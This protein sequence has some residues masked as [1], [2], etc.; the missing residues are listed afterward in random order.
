MIQQPA[1]IPRHRL[2]GHWSPFFRAASSV[3]RPVFAH[4]KALGLITGLIVAVGVTLPIVASMHPLGWATSPATNARSGEAYVPGA[5]AGY[6]GPEDWA[7]AEGG[8]IGGYAYRPGPLAGYDGPEVW[9]LAEGGPFGSVILP[10]PEVVQDWARAEGG[11]F[12]L[13]AY[14]P[15]PLAGYDGPEAWALAEGGVSGSEITPSPEVAQDR[16]RAEGGY[17]W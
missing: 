16:A 9:A 17:L 5:L 10:R 11:P 14:Q 3:R 6:A 7:L 15:G 2:S 12:G 1:E 13:Y 8:A 4:P